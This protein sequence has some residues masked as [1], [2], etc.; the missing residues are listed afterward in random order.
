MEA[1]LSTMYCLKQWE[2]R[3]VETICTVTRFLDLE[4]D[5]QLRE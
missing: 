4:T 3:T 2:A 5:V 1:T